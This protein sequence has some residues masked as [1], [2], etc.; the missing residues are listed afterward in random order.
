MQA[1]VYISTFP[2][3]KSL[4]DAM[5]VFAKRLYDA[6]LP[7]DIVLLILDR[8][9]KNMISQLTVEISAKVVCVQCEDFD[10]EIA[11]A[12]NRAVTF[13]CIRALLVLEISSRGKF[14]LPCDFVSSDLNHLVI[15]NE[16]GEIYVVN[17]S[18]ISMKL[19]NP[20]QHSDKEYKVIHKTVWIIGN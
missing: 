17:S 10:I 18:Y 15:N 1:T 7:Y 5:N 16:D 2:N 6:K 12:R 19:S 13:D 11:N 4:V 8:A 14:L 3:V 20:N 9:R